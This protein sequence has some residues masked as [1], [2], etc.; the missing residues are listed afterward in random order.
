MKQ[1]VFEDTAVSENPTR[2][3]KHTIKLPC[4]IAPPKNICF[5][6]STSRCNQVRVSTPGTTQAVT[7]KQN[8]WLTYF[9]N[10][11]NRKEKHKWNNLGL[12]LWMSTYVLVLKSQPLEPWNFTFS[13]T[14]RYFWDW[15]FNISKYKFYMEMVKAV[16]LRLVSTNTDTLDKRMW[17][18]TVTVR[19]L[20]ILT[21]F[22][23]MWFIILYKPQDQD[24]R[25][26]PA[27]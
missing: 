18:N 9:S 3:K 10:Q 22:E 24:H 15:A 16:I 4:R 19:T 17:T 21:D 2:N 23:W 12:K 11:T 8:H 20:Y 5:V 26:N 7:S 14:L 25:T 1:F 27:I 6:P 13:D